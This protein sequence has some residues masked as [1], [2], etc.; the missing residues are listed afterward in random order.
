ME[1]AVG[2]PDKFKDAIRIGMRFNLSSGVLSLI[3][4]LVLLAVGMKHECISWN[5]IEK[6]KNRTGTESRY[7]YPRMSVEIDGTLDFDSVHLIHLRGC[8]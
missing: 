3:I 6:M 2:D 8:F 5:A 4:N 1:E 7:V